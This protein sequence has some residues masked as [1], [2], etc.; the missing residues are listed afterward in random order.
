M[1]RSAEGRPAALQIDCAER[2]AEAVA[3]LRAARADIARLAPAE[4]PV[5]IEGP[6]PV[7]GGYLY[8][9]DFGSATSPARRA[10]LP[11]ILARHLEDAGIAN[12]VIRPARRISTRY[13][14]LSSFAPT[15]R[16]WLVGTNT[17]PVSG[18]LPSVPP[19][20]VDVATQWLQA[21]HDQNMELLAVVLGL[22]IPL[23]PETLPLFPAYVRTAGFYTFATLATD[24]ASTYASALFGQFRG[25]GVT[26][27]EAG[28]PAA[29]AVALMRDQRELIRAHAHLAEL[30]WA[31][32]SA[33]GRTPR[34]LIGQAS[35]RSYQMLGP[36]WYQLLS[37]DQSRGPGPIQPG[38]IELPG[39]RLELTVGEPEQWLPGRLLAGFLRPV[40]LRRPP[41]RRSPPP[42]WRPS[43]AP[44]GPGFKP[45]AHIK[46]Q[47]GSRV[48][49]GGR[50]AVR[51]RELVIQ[52]RFC[53]PLVGPLQEPVHLQVGQR[54][55]VG[56]GP[57]ELGRAVGDAAEAAYDADPCAVSVFRSVMV[58]REV[59]VSC[60]EGR[61][62]A[63]VRSAI[64]S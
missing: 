14:I 40:P 36:V 47:G 33:A 9:V 24:F 23:S 57:G 18:V 15:V 39:G 5:A 64:W 30:E 27:A 32:V 58:A 62:R 42:T 21:R 19:V 8:W 10:E 44:N 50:E 45:V 54:A 60:G 4:A 25:T 48:S 43:F 20:L 3:A 56:Q 22:E 29:Q 17:E 16:T 2:P 7:P 35:V 63:R 37:A 53:G 55:G 41:H 51:R 1:L 52:G 28:R 38:A 6:I 61:W 13:E 59:P 12:A 49:A 34:P 46:L 26:L 11:D 31:G